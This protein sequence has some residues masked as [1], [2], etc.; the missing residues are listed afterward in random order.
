MVGGGAAGAS[1]ALFLARRDVAV[2][3][4]DDGRA[5]YS[6]PYETVLAQTRDTWERLDL[7]RDVDEGA[8]PDPLRHG[9]I[10]GTEELTWRDDPTPG[11]I[12]Q[13]GAFDRALRRA[14]AAAGARV[15]EE[16]T[17]TPAGDDWRVD[18]AL[19][20][21]RVVAIATGRRPAGGGARRYVRGRTRTLAVTLTGLPGSRDRGTAV[22]EAVRSGWLWSYAPA[23]GPASVAAL[24]DAPGGRGGLRAA[25]NAMLE[26]AR[27]PAG[28]LR[29]PVMVQANDASPRLRVDEP[30]VLLL[31]DAAATID[32][33]ASQGVEKGVAA[34]EHAATVIYSAL[35]QPG[36]WPRLRRLHARWERELCAAHWR[37]SAEFY[38]QERRF[39]D[40]PFWRARRSPS[41]VFPEAPSLD[42]EAP[43]RWREGVSPGPALLRH[44]DRFVEVAG[45][46]DAVRGDEL[47]RVGRVP[48]APLY[49]L[50]Q[51]AS[52]SAAALTAAR[53]DAS[54]VTTSPRD[55]LD[56]IAWLHAKGW[57]ISS[58]PSAPAGR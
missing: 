39:D 47:A 21:P 57:L 17:A 9:A 46:T 18:D 34:A 28:R 44:G 49:G 10:W 51:A 22:V 42:A 32:P 23:S 58:T 19:L 16:T 14:A 15:L 26:E 43:L 29:D 45:L 25:L 5:H 1:L 38:S 27:G 36:W 56:A 7:L 48:A 37:T 40:A 33:L 6:G 52:T 4:V 24:L 31:G 8:R 53:Q 20:S 30:G 50:L 41:D 3:L 35:A 11:L 13:R 12:L 55:L 2:T 54:F